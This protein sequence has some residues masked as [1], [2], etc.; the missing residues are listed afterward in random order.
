MRYRPV[1]GGQRPE[2]FRGQ[3]DGQDPADRPQYPVH[4]FQR[5][6]HS[7]EHGQ[8]EKAAQAHERGRRVRVAEHRHHEA[9]IMEEKHPLLTSRNIIMSYRPPSVIRGFELCKR[10]SR[11]RNYIIIHQGWSNCG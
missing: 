8:R 10:F 7:A 1:P 9:Y 11:A 5:P 6:N 4:A 3:G 2:R